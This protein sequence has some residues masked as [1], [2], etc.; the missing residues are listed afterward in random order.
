MGLVKN[1]MFLTY[2]LICLQSIVPAMNSDQVK[3][4]LS[5]DAPYQFFDI[6][7]EEEITTL[8]A[9]K[10]KSDK[11]EGVHYFTKTTK[12]RDLEGFLQDIENVHLVKDAVMPIIFKIYQRILQKQQE[13]IPDKKIM[14]YSCIV[15]ENEES[16]VDVGWHIDNAIQRC[17]LS[18]D[19]IEKAS[20]RI[21]VPLF[22]KGTM[23]ARN[24]ADDQFLNMFC[25]DYACNNPE[26]IKAIH[27]TIKPEDCDY[28]RVGQGVILDR[29]RA[30]HMRPLTKEPRALMIVDFQ[31][32]WFS[33]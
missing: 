33:F 32:K 13:M 2:I 4:K 5:Q 22:G 17:N 21:M 6:L 31:K 9:M 20:H 10:V 28:L 27:A 12:N 3:N 1:R 11:F 24:S 15:V 29:N 26:I 8:A 30:V 23:F 25:P 16:F 7:S 18:I 19:E 14:H